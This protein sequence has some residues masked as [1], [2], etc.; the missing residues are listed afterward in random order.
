VDEQAYRELAERANSHWF[1]VE[2]R[3]H[4]RAVI[5][6]LALPP[7][8]RILEIGC[9]PGSNLGMLRSFGEVTAVEP[10]AIARALLR[11]VPE[12]ADVDLRDGLWPDDPVLRPGERFDLVAMLDVLEH[13]DDDV[14]ALRAAREVLAPGGRVLVTVPAHPWMWSVHDEH[15]HHRRRYT[16]STLR[17]AFSEA[18]LSLERLGGFNAL[19]LP[20]AAAARLAARALRRATSPGRDTPAPFVNTVLGAL[21][22]SERPVIVRGGFPTGL[23]L[24]AIA[25][26]P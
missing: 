7:R 19:L 4:L 26:H 24:L 11:S 21:F 9:G 15:L 14:A 22:R 10:S 18:G 23:S 5:T 16:R 2:R 3:A 8:A 1:A 20:A 17:S 6:G 12:I 25:R 13:I